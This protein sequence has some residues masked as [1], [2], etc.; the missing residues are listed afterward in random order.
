MEFVCSHECTRHLKYIVALV[1]DDKIHYCCIFVGLKDQSHYLLG[2]LERKINKVLITIN[3]FHVHGSLNAREKYWF[4]RLFCAKINVSELCGRILLAMPVANVGIDHSLVT[5]IVNM[6]F[7]R[8][9]PTYYQQRGRGGR[10]PDMHCVVHHISREY[11]FVYL[12]GFYNP[13]IK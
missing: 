9:L 12:Y 3:V 5:N 10:T 13:P 11:A 4:I 6:R 2:E 1:K 8:D 7:T